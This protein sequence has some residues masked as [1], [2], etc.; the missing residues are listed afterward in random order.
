MRAMRYEVFAWADAACRARAA[1]EH[2]LAPM[3][4]GM[5]AYGAWVRGAFE[6]A[7]SL[8]EETRRLEA[9]LAVPPTGLAERVLGNVL[10]IIDQSAAGNRES[11]RQVE[12][13]EASG[14]RSRLVHACYMASVALST[15]GDHD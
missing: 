10:Y 14:N 7:V 11:A 2:P 8:A 6:L 5:R 15:E 4:T 9:A 13:A 1:L 12:L 3:L